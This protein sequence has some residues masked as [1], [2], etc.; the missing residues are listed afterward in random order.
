MIFNYIILTVLAIVLV[1][2]CF[3]LV[4]VNT[5]GN[6][7]KQLQTDI[8]E[9]KVSSAV[10]FNQLDSIIEN[11]KSYRYEVQNLKDQISFLRSSS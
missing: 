10:K 2:M 1:V 5:L 8:T 7:I 4:N 9:I 6:S 3:V 11:M